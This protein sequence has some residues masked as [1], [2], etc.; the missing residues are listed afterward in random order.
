MYTIEITTNLE[1]L[2][3]KTAQLDKLVN[4]INDFKFKGTFKKKGNT[5]EYSSNLDEIS[6]KTTQ[7]NKLINQINSFKIKAKTKKIKT[8]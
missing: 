6:D 5:N 7:L 2:N 8:I 3:K 4:E 1:E